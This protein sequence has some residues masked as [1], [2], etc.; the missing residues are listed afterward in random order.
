MHIFFNFIFAAVSDSTSDDLGDKPVQFSSLD[1]LV[2]TP[3]PAN[4][5]AT[6]AHEPV[7]DWGGSQLITLAQPVLLE[8]RKA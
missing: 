7:W 4:G 2:E 6:S 8:Y 5:H 3:E 1:T